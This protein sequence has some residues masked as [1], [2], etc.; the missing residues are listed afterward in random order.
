MFRYEMSTCQC[1]WGRSGWMNPVPF[2][3][4]EVF[5]RLSN[6]AFESTRYTEDGLA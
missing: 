2:F 6:P 4:G 1:W 3:V 5:Q